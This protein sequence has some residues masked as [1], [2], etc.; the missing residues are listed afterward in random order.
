MLNDLL[1]NIQCNTSA[2]NRINNH[3]YKISMIQRKDNKLH[4]NAAFAQIFQFQ[5]IRTKTHSGAQGG[6][7]ESSSGC[8][9]NVPGV[10]HQERSLFQQTAGNTHVVDTEETTA[11]KRNI[12]R[13]V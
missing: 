3:Y 13:C 10:M 4:L 12:P 6:G 8:P 1:I 5:M 7:G 2:I 11:G 9:V